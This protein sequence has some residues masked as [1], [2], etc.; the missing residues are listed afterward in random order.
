MRIKL[1]AEDH[2]QRQYPSLPLGRKLMNNTHKGHKII[3]STSRLT[4]T[5]WEPR[6]TVI[7]SEDGDGKL[8]KLTVNRAFR[9]RR[10]AE[11]EGLT[12]AKKW[13]DDGKPDLSL[14]SAQ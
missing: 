14:N 10:E 5:R 1:D 7:W 4:A 12:F 2:N 6:V 9:V 13:I 3:V 8:S 11:M